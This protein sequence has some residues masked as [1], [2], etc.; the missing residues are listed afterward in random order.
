MVEDLRAF[1]QLVVGSVFFSLLFL[2]GTMM[3]QSTKRRISEFGVMRAIGF[4]SRVITMMVISEVSA[5]LVGGAS[6]AMI[7]ATFAFPPVF[8]FVGL[9]ALPLPP[10]IYPNVLII[11]AVSVILTSVWPVM[12]LHNLSITEAMSGR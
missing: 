11:A 8:A 7:L 10:S 3:I 2:V 12:H 6:I 5:L 9:I 4:S 1:V